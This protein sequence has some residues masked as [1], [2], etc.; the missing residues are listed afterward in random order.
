MFNIYFWENNKKHPWGLGRNHSTPFLSQNNTPPQIMKATNGWVKYSNRIFSYPPLSIFYLFLFLRK[1]CSWICGH[2][3]GESPST[4][5]TT[6]AW[7]WKETKIEKEGKDAIPIV[8]RLRSLQLPS[9]KGVQRWMLRWYSI[10]LGVSGGPQIFTIGLMFSKIGQW[11]ICLK[12][13]MLLIW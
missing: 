4:M 10:F 1:E 3:S 13:F 8:R 7:W 2:C 11:S 9:G 12:F 6:Y 5:L